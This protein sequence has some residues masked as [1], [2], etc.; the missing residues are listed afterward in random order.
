MPSEIFED[1][2]KFKSEVPLKTII[3]LIIF[4]L[5]IAGLIEGHITQ[6]I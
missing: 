5:L 4:Y 2:E 1:V 6:N 3:P